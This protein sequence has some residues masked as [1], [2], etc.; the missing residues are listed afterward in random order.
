MMNLTRAQNIID[1]VK[2]DIDRYLKNSPMLTEQFEQA[3]LAVLNVHQAG[4]A[5]FHAALQRPG[6]AQLNG[7]A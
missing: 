7:L 6:I 2:P 5:V 1:C 3:V 4:I